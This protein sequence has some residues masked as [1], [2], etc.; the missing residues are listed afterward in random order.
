MERTHMYTDSPSAMCTDT[1]KAPK[2]TKIYRHYLTGD[3]HMSVI[4][5]LY[6]LVFGLRLIFQSDP[7]TDGTI[8]RRQTDIFIHM[9]GTD[10]KQREAD[11]PQ[12]DIHKHVGTE[13]P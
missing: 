10:T 8:G 2:D 1:Q 6:Q 7:L 9:I 3:T 12:S 5:P 13:T 4:D 11:R